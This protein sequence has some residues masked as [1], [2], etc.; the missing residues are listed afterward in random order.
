M[1]MNSDSVKLAFDRWI[2]NVATVVAQVLDSF[3][4][5]RTVA[6][7][8]AADGV[9]QISG[10]DTRA[11]RLVD[12]AFAC[13]DGRAVE[14][15]LRGARVSL[16][17]PPG[18]FLFRE[19]DLPSRAIEFLDGVLR[20]QIDRLTP[21]S[22]AQAV[23]GH[24][25]PQTAGH[26]RIKLVI[27]AAP[28]AQIDPII[29]AFSAAGANSAVIVA[30]RE[31]ADAAPPIVVHE[32]AFR[33]EQAAAEAQGVLRKAL[34]G[35]LAFAGLTAAASGIL[36]AW[37]DA[38]TADVAAETHQWRQAQ[39]S[40]ARDPDIMLH[41]RKF[42]SPLTVLVLEQLARIL[43]DDTYLRE[44]QFSE[45]KLEIAGVSADATRL[46][47]MLERSPTFSRAT[48]SAPT[49]HAPNEPGDQFHIQAQVNARYG[50]VE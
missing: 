42:G 10:D 17:L 44:F 39:M 32:S 25:A 9:F 20:A 13:D 27:A 34:V 14:P 45:G 46:V 1:K 47:A 11:F 23:F 19:L 24:S 4:R 16:A 21:W 6:I 22:P 43:P 37:F 41:K 28:L 5:P 30:Q 12:G 8:G 36:G 35:A 18:M 29:H 2:A 7:K 15:L 3:A 40:G 48:F 49:T 50:Q 33:R 26:D 31:N 38:R